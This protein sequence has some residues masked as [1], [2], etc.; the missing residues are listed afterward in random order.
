[1]KI[2]AYQSPASTQNRIDIIELVRERVLECEANGISVLCCAEAI[3]GGLADYDENPSRLALQHDGGQLAS[4]L[5]PLASEIVTSIV[6]FT[7][8]GR[9]GALYNVAAVFQHGRVIGVYRKIHPA[10]RR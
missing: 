8:L 10:I 5:M 1:M 2:A 4:V 9:N 7:E 6:G 3:I